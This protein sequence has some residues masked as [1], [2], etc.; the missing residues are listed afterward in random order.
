[1]KYKIYRLC[2]NKKTIEKLKKEERKYRLPKTEYSTGID[3]FTFINNILKNS[4]EDFALLCHE[5]VII[6]ENIESNM[7]NCIES[8]NKYVGENNWG[9]IGN[10]GLKVLSKETIT[11]LSDP[12]TRILPPRTET[13]EIAES[14]DGNTMLLNLKT[15][16]E[17]NV[18]MPSNLKGYHLYD[19]IF[20]LETYKKGLMC[21]ISSWLYVKHLSCG[22]YDSFIKASKEKQF[23]EYFKKNFS[24]HTI[25]S[26][27]DNIPIDRD[28]LYLSNPEK[29]SPPSVESIVS[30]T[31]SSIFKENNFDLHILTR[32]HIKSNKIYRLF[33]SIRILNQKL[34]PKIK[35]HIHI[36]I[37]NISEKDIKPFIEKLKSEYVELDIQEKYI[38]N[39]SR[40][41]RV[42]SLKELVLDLE[43]K[44]NSF[45]WI[46]DYDDFIIPMF[47]DN[48]QFMLSNSEIFIG[49]STI[50]D[51]TWREDET[52]PISSRFRYF[53]SYKDVNNLYGGVNSV[54]VCSCIYNVKVI[55]E[56]FEENEILGDYYE[57]YAILLLA[58]MKHSIR[59][60]P[61]DIAGI[62]YHGTN[63][64]LEKDRTHWDYSY[65]TFLSEIVNKGLVNKNLF[66]LTRAILSE[67]RCL[68]TRVRD[69][70]AEKTYLE[71]RVA[72][73]DAFRSG[74]IWKALTKYRNLKKFLR[75]IRRN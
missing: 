18:S 67:K 34:N 12:H 33:D 26:I 2:R 50:F 68:E 43:N 25:T 6:P 22:N 45:A 72:E 14:L 21:L 46:V 9:I 38:K 65:A 54:P 53:C 66:K 36:G 73:F 61:I 19:L 51:E 32:L 29:E 57:D 52:I 37:N 55:R 8:A 27:N 47:S 13:P 16:R 70:Q 49:N 31:I 56:V 11:Y 10:A 3:M 15:L 39:I 42:D 5:D 60:Y 41:A 4:K 17:K 24:N 20:S 75:K 59:N 7:K 30:K 64:V 71:T 44:E 69:I 48:I 58:S 74:L 28:Y 63:T 40:Y 1:M 35:L 23:Q 62:S